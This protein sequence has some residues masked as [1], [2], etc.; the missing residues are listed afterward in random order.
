METQNKMTYTPSV[1]NGEPVIL[2]RF[3]YDPEL[4][5]EVKKPSGRKWDASLSSCSSITTLRLP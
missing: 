4:V 2:I 3:K 1:H 5:A